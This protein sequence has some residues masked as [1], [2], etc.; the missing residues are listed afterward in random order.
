MVAVTERLTKVV[1]MVRL[2]LEKKVAVLQKDINFKIRKLFLQCEGDFSSAYSVVGEL[3][4]FVGQ[5]VSQLPRSMAAGPPQ[6]QQ[7]LQF[8]QQQTDVV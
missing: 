1:G 3:K 6:V 5:S 8:Q 4:L 7:G 2:D